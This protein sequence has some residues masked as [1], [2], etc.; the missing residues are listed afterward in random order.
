MGGGMGRNFMSQ[1]FGN[2]PA[3]TTF[4]RV[5]TI[6]ELS[7]QMGAVLGSVQWIGITIFLIMLVLVAA[8]ITNTYRMVLMER[9]KEIGMLRCIGFRRADIFRIFI[10]E[11]GLIAIAG[12]LAGIIASLPVGMLIHL[13][14]FNPSGS[15]GSALARGRLTF[16]PRLLSLAAIC[17]AVIAASVFAVFGPARKASKLQPVEALRTT[18]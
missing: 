5:A 18:A 16:A 10:Y 1:I 11:A 17:L 15:L 3:G 13:V 8:G 12:S 2:A 7:G 4:Y 9:T 14:P 6:T